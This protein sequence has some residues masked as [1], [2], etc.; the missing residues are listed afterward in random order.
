MTYVI[1]IDVGTSSVRGA[2]VTKSGEVVKVFVQPI[3]TW[4]PKANFYQQSTNEIWSVCSIIIKHLISDVSP[5]EVKGIGFDATSSMVVLDSKGNPVSV[6]PGDNDEQNVMLW[7]DHRA[8]EE[9]KFIN[10]TKHPV[11]KY[12]G[13]KISVEMMAPKI[14]WL[15]KNNPECWKKAAYFL[16][17]PDFMTYRATG[18]E[19]RSLCSLVCDCNF[20]HFPDDSYWCEEFFDVIGLADLADE[21]FKKVGNVVIKPGELCGKLTAKAA[22]ETGLLSGTPVSSALIDAHAGGLGVMGCSAE[23][24]SPDFTTRL[25]MICGTSACHMAQTKKEIQVPGV[26]GPFYNIMVPDLWLL[27]GGQSV[28]GRLIDHI[29]DT[30]PASIQIKQKCVDKH[31]TQ[32][33]NDLLY[34]KAKKQNLTSI[35]ELTK[36]IHIWPDFHG[37][38]SPVADQELRGMI[39]GLTLAHDEEDLAIRY[40][41]TIQALAYGT[42][43]I[44]DA[45]IEAGHNVIQSVILCGGVSKNKVYVNTHANAIG[46]QV[47]IPEETE[48]VLLGA[49][50]LG[51]SVAGFYENLQQAIR[52]MAGPAK[53][54]KPHADVRS[55][56]DK[57]YQVFLEMLNHQKLIRSIMELET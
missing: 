13:G 38:R 24:V 20:Q 56:H 54:V 34:E 22:L 40:L 35:D 32:Y 46:L 8:E 30:H 43:H 11:L 10:K 45:M 15:K 39:N 55:Y 53:H 52:E 48:S 28:S 37:N 50:M 42:K 7:M 2:L 12:V 51:A 36:D 41:A 57:K 19:H 29:I 3:T 27:K 49:A 25:A 6:N 9:T 47:L 1:G 16:S 44:I 18:E 4:N 21:N 17:L 5:R 26:W 23:H 33:L 14:L 31:I